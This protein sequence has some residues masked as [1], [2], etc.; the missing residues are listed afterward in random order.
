MANILYDNCFIS[1]YKT[2]VKEVVEENGLYWHYLEET[3]FFV[4]S[5]GMESDQGLIN[6]H[7]VLKLKKEYNKVWHL[8]DVKLEGSVDLSIDFHLRLTRSQIHTAQ[9]LISGIMENVY[10]YQTISHH[11][12]GN[13]NDIEFDTDVIKERTLHELQVIVNGLIRDDLRVGIFYPTK[14]EMSQYN[15][16]N[17]GLYDEVRMVSI[18]KITTTPCGC[19]H[20][21]SLRYLQMIK[22]NG[23]EKSAKGVKIRYVCGDQLL[24]NYDRYYDVLSKAGTLLAQPFDY[25]ELGI[26]K[27]MQEIK[28]QQADLT[29]FRTKYVEA[30]IANIDANKKQYRVFDAMD[31]RTFTL[32]ANTYNNIA[33]AAFIFLW[34]QE[35][36]MHIYVGAK[37]R[38][39]EI[40]DKI[41]EEYKVNGGGN[42]TNAQGGGAYQE[43]IEDFLM[44]IV[45]EI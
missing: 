22:I 38:S 28:N 30:L 12:H 39:V 41:K 5:G 9:H 2:N 31:L 43:G 7:K 42:E 35:K 20:V 23:I 44:K 29:M 11:L 16:K 24:N 21:P 8:L 13:Y 19:I 36:R 45:E 14:M 10:G 4:E 25:I 40:F 18:G 32:L 26:L 1:S 3:I 34:K 15:I 37:A 27:L 6:Q 17:V 33:N